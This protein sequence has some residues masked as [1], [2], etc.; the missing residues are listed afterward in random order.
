MTSNDSSLADQVALVTGASSGIE[1]ATAEL[2]AMEG[3][4]VA[5]A[6]RREDELQTLAEGLEDDYGIETVVIP[7]DMTEQAQT[8]AMIDRTVDTF[9]GLDVLVNNAGV[10]LLEPTERA[11]LENYQQSIELNLLGLM[12][13]TKLALPALK[14]NDGGDIINISSIAGRVAHAG[15]GAYSASKFGVTAFSEVLR[16][17]TAGEGVRVSVIEPRAVDTALP[18]HITDEETR[19]QSQNLYESLDMLHPEDIA[20]A[21]RYIVTRPSRVGIN[22][23]VVRPRDQESP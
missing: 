10:I 20:D 11:S 2:L 6:A 1:E 17:E 22:E 5:V 16:E 15:S 19:E 18:D 7:T 21:I 12:T 9:G 3:A 13:A 4:N 23:L 8:E 14:E